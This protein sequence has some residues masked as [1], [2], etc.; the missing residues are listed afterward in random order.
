MDDKIEVSPAKRR[1]RASRAG[2]ARRFQCKYPA[3]EKR[4][5]RAEHLQ[6]HTLNHAPEKIFFCEIPR[7]GLTFV[8]ADLYARHKAR[9]NPGSSG[10]PREYKSARSE[11]ITSQMQNTDL[12]QS[13]G[14][15]S[16]PDQ[17]SHNDFM[18]RQPSWH[19][20]PGRDQNPAAASSQPASSSHIGNGVDIP[21]LSC[22]PVTYPLIDDSS[23]HNNDNFAAWLFDAPS[24]YD[25]GFSLTNGPSLDFG[26][27]YSSNYTWTPGSRVLDLE[28]L[29]S[30]RLEGCVSERRRREIHSVLMQFLSKQRGQHLVRD[31]ESILLMRN[32]DFPNLTIEM[33]DRLIENYWLKVSAQI[34]IVH[35]PTFTSNSCHLLLLLA[36][37]AL[38]AADLVNSQPKGYLVEYK[39]L[40]DLIITH[41]RWEIFTYEDAEPPVQLWVAQTLLLL[42]FYEKQWSTRR[43]HERA[44]I[45]HASTLTLLRRGSPLVGQTDDIIPPGEFLHRLSESGERSNTKRDASQAVDNWWV[46]WVGNESFNRVVFTA[47]WMDTLH[48]SMY[49]HAAD[50]APYEIRTNFPCDESLWT[51]KSAEE[52]QRLNGDLKVCGVRQISFLEG[53][54]QSLHAQHVQTHSGARMLLMAGLLSVGWHINRREKHLQFLENAPSSREQG[55]WRSLLLNAFGHWRSSF[56]EAVGLQNDGVHGNA[57][58]N[59]DAA[60][61]LLHLAQ[62]TMHAD[63]IDCQIFSGSIRLLGRKVSKHDYLN[64]LQRMRVWSQGPLALHAVQHSTRLL[65]ETLVKPSAH[66]QETYHGLVSHERSSIKYSCRNDSIILR[67][68]AVY[69]AA[70]IMWAYQHASASQL[71]TGISGPQY[72]EALDDEAMCCR[73]LTTCAGVEDSSQ[74]PRVLS[75]EGGLPSVLNVVSKDLANAEPEL[76]LEA[77]TRLQTCRA[78]L[79]DANII[80]PPD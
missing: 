76:L 79:A 64:V 3:C 48:A 12:H 61:V 32:G 39:E 19:A 24:S 9:H 73:Y 4:Y 20:E 67:P 68:W 8:R 63:L 25:E 42:E 7:C 50:M 55:R 30:N 62:M 40:A 80:W 45:H 23:A 35:Q 10:I 71:V 74:L 21:R 51:A 6:R 66:R 34:S 56:D 2:Q 47:F 16:I 41:L 54:K 52:V 14:S 60:I 36:I 1:P 5:S 11:L 33:L 43:L 37:I 38:G 49:G 29:P 26:L 78:M 59:A 72:L 65:Y 13:G 15:D 75:Q 44:H 69:L 31:N 28:D 46:H 53:L 58:Q 77:A 27:E 18:S 57:D 70:L 22:V 17:A